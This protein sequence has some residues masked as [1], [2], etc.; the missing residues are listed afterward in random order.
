MADA[1]PYG[2][3]LKDTQ[4]NLK[5]LPPGA[6]AQRTDPAAL[7]DLQQAFGYT[8]EDLK[9][10]LAPMAGAG[11]DPVGSMGTDTPL[12]GA[13][14][15]AALALRL[16]QAEFRPGHQPADRSDPR[17]AGDVAGVDDRAAAEPARP[18]G[19]HAQAA[20]S[21]AADP[22]QRGPREDPRHRGDARRR[23]PHRHARR[24]LAET[25][26][27]PVARSGAAAPVLGSDRG[28]ARRHQ[29][30]DPVGPGRRRTASRSRPL[31]PPARSTI[32]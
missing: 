32:I 10:F 30:A 5:D 14:G 29:R 23:L 19:R 26:R 12:R 15:P 18:P 31:W 20:R 4:F 25:W 24:H 2:D 8:D 6:S 17:G 16:F 3:W 21:L 28:G 13:V 11:D 9:F 7:R 27:R 22:D 1:A